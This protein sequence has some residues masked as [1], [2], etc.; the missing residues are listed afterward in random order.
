MPCSAHPV[1]S[2]SL[3]RALGASMHPPSA[4]AP[5]K[6]IGYHRAQRPQS[7]SRRRSTCPC[8]WLARTRTCPENRSPTRGRSIAALRPARER[9]A[10]DGGGQHAC[11][12]SKSAPCTG[13]GAALSHCGRG[14]VVVLVVVLVV[15]L[16]RLVMAAGG[17]LTA[18][19]LRPSTEVRCGGG[20]RLGHKRPRSLKLGK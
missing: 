14:K 3:R 17:E 16:M 15:M 4:G 2:L 13:S 6:S 12:R 18:P 1:Q 10:W 7:W 8:P 9:H 20:R 5:A 11:Q 19:A